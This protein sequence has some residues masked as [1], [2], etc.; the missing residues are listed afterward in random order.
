MAATFMKI[1]CLAFALCSWLVDHKWSSFASQ[2]FYIQKT[3]W[4]LWLDIL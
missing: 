1:S 4:I 2:M 3:D